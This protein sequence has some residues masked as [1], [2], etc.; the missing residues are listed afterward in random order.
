MA[1]KF[2]SMLLK[3]LTNIQCIIKMSRN[4]AMAKGISTVL[5]KM[6]AIFLLQVA[7]YLLY[8]PVVDI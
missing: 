3:I 2:S 7:R 8:I 4:P 6:H 1:G 5:Y